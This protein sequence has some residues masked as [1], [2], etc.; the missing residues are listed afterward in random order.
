M[1]ES[2][3]NRPSEPA[4]RGFPFITAGISLLTFFVFAGLTVLA[5]R[6]PNYL[7]EP[8]I[9][10]KD[11]QNEKVDPATRLL[12]LRAKNQAVLDGRPGT[13]TKMSV[14]EATDKL[15]V[16]VKTGKDHLPFPIPEPAAPPAPE[17]KKDAKDKK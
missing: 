2:N 16:N 12:E 7:A 6:S 10:P 1:S 11:A 17:P 15:L 3:L 9:D 4:P 8:T 14:A 13:G 5:Y